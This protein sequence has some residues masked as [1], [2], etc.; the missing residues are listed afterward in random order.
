MTTT[1]E[2]YAVTSGPG[3]E[4]RKVRS[5]FARIVNDKGLHYLSWL[6]GQWLPNSAL[7]DHFYGKEGYRTADLVTGADA[8]AL[9]NRFGTTVEAGER[10]AV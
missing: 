7:T 3:P 1:T 5:I 2:I 9:C 8:D 4:D 6:E 10:A